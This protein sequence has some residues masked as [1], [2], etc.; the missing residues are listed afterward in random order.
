MRRGRYGRD[1]GRR[2]SMLRRMCAAKCEA[3]GRDHKSEQQTNDS[4]HG[5]PFGHTT[6]RPI[7]NQRAN[8]QHALKEWLQCALIQKFTS[9][10]LDTLCG[11]PYV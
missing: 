4:K 1:H 6:R 7:T 5:V 9:E 8:R 10:L 3:G 2:L 11:A